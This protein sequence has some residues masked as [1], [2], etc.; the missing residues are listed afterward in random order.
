MLLVGTSH[1]PGRA[2]CLHGRPGGSAGGLGWQKKHCR[3]GGRK[4]PDEATA[5]I[6][7]LPPHQAHRETKTVPGH[8]RTPCIKTASE[9]G[10]GFLP[11]V[12]S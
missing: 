2:P 9:Y 4:E 10:P 1:T 3:S 12:P 5:G 6:T 7:P 8:T 11:K